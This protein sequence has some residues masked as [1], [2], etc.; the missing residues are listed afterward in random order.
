VAGAISIAGTHSPGSSPG[1]QTFGSDLSDSTGANVDWELIANDAASGSAGTSYDQI[2]VGG[3]LDFAGATTLDLIFNASGS[4]VDWTDTFWNSDQAWVM[5]DDLSS[6]TVSN[7]GNLSINT[8]SWLD[9]N[10]ASFATARP[11]A[12]FTVSQLG[13]DVLLVYTAVPEPSALIMLPAAGLALI[14]LRQ[15]RHRKTARS[16]G[17][18]TA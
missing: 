10:S 12:S 3:N 17:H 15:L 8:S 7:L 16:T 2:G 11:D 18:V 9:S 13:Q 14:G 5:W 6:G 4:A 1:L